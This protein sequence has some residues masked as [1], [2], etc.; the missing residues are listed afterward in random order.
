MVTY[1]YRCAQDGP[2]EL[3]APMG[4]APPRAPCPACD[5]GARRAFLAPRLGSGRADLVRAI[6]RTKASAD[7]PE[8][9]SRLP[10]SG[11]GGRPV[12]TNPLHRTLPRP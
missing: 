11:R 2:F 10:V 6:D 5:T 9:V 3:R 12:T 4:H 7:T 8:V 1:E